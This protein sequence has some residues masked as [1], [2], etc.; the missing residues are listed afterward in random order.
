MVDPFSPP[1]LPK[2]SMQQG[3]ATIQLHESS[4]LNRFQIG[5][6]GSRHGEQG[7]VI[8]A[9]LLLLFDRNK[10]FDISYC[11]QQNPVNRPLLLH[12]RPFIQQYFP[13]CR[14]SKIHQVGIPFVEIDALAVMKPIIVLRQSMNS[15]FV[16][17]RGFH[18]R[19]VS[20]YSS[21]ACAQTRQIG[22]LPL[23]QLQEEYRLVAQSF[24]RFASS[25]SVVD[26]K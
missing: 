21:P 23:T 2:N 19:Q 8:T 16:P 17:N 13:I 26:I 6:T 14:R 3:G 11:I 7:S 1:V 5:E 12:F 25:G 15:L 18:D 10:F 4:I 9:Y 24:E 20:V 22:R